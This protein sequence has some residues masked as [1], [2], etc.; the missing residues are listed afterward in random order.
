[1]Q[2]ILG[3]GGAIGKELA[4]SLRSYTKTLRLVSRNPASENADDEIVAADLTNAEQVRKAVQGSEIVYLMAGLVYKAKVWKEQWPKIMQNVINACVEFNSK[5][6]FFDNIYLYDGSRL[7]PITE[8]NPINPPSKKGAVRAELVKMI[9]EAAENRQLKVLIARCAD[10]YGPSIKN[11]SILT[12]TIL[13]PLSEN[14][15]ANVLVADKY[16]HSFTY[17]RDAATAT[18]LLGNTEDAYG[19]TWHLPTA[20]NP[21]TAKEWVELAAKELGVAPKYRIVGKGMVRLLG[22]FIPVMKESYEMLYQYDKD[23]VFNSDKFDKRFNFIPTSYQDGMR[24]IAR[25]DYGR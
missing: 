21:L 6:V 19:Q 18:A 4:V 23:Y 20:K 17:S 14:K 2:T 25:I 13:K 11:T 9:W 12:E 5:L 10:F 7:N 8:E 16:L 24:E 3:A 1:M 15:T 22:L